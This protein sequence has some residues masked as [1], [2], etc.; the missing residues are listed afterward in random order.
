MGTNQNACKGRSTFGNAVARLPVSLFIYYAAFALHS[1]KAFMDR[2]NFD[3]IFG[4]SWDSVGAVINLLVFLLLFLKL[5]SQRSSMS[6]WAVILLGISVGYLSWRASGESWAFWAVLFVLSAEDV[7]I[8]PL[9][10]ITLCTTLI[11]LLLSITASNLGL[12]ENIIDF[13]SNGTMRQSLGFNHA[14]T[15]GLTIM[16]A[17]TAFSVIRFDESPLFS[18]FALLFGIVIL[19]VVADARSAAFLCV[20]QICFLVIFHSARVI[21][22]KRFWRRLFIVL[23]SAIIVL[24]YYYMIFYNP[25]NAVHATLDNMLSYRLSL[26]HGY[27]SLKP[28]TLFGSDFTDVRPLAWDSEGQ[29]FFM[30]DNAYCHLLIRNG[31]LMAA[32]YLIGLFALLRR[33]VSEKRWDVILFGIT[34]LS[35]YGLS[36]NMALYIECNY[37]LVVIGAQILFSHRGGSK[38]SG[39]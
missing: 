3:Y 1:F 5:V 11:V 14:N 2:T 16:T 7:K 30:L 34:I 21:K 20:V 29:P 17:C 22:T 13:R 10:E 36:E 4:M 12:I 26:A 31:I 9:A 37:F 6:R 8:K 19:L 28:L 23:V 35:I 18:I 33:F 27:Y 15:L 32:L 24:S 25:A 38:I 39:D